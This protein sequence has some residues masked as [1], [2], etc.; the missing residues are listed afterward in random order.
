MP[1]YEYECSKCG[2]RREK[3]RPIRERAHKLSCNGSNCDGKMLPMINYG[4][5]QMDPVKPVRKPHGM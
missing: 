4:S 2:S 3:L 1:L 5:F